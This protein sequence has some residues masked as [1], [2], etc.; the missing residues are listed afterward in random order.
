MLKDLGINSRALG[1]EVERK[2]NTFEKDF[3]KKRPIMLKKKIT[4]I[5]VENTFEAQN[6]SQVRPS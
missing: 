4:G 2:G 3:F 1:R 6:N 5:Q